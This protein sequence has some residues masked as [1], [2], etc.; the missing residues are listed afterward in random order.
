MAKVL[1]IDDSAFIRGRHRDFLDAAGHQCLDTG[2][3]EMA[4][5]LFAAER[6]DV[7]VLDLMMPGMGGLELM[8]RLLAI[9]P[10]A[11]VI[12]CSADKQQSRQKQARERGAA[13]FL[14]KPA[15]AAS[16]QEAIDQV[17]GQVSGDN[18]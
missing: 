2:S 11:R 12:I 7:V 13:C 18:S 5:Q 10:G 16:L 4:L 6:P 1:I 15:S 9:E 17:L 14:G 8:D 3:G